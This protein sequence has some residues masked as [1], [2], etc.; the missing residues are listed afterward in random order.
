MEYDIIPEVPDTE[1][2]SN[3]LTLWYEYTI[4]LINLVGLIY[5]AL[6]FSQFCKSVLFRKIIV[7][8]VSF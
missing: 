2:F 3:P 5:L 1:R 4:F 8:Q 7:A 6:K